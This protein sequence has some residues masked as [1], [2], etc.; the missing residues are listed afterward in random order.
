MKACVVRLRATIMLLDRD[1][2]PDGLLLNGHVDIESLEASLGVRSPHTVSKR[3]SS[4]SHL[5]TWFLDETPKTSKS[6]LSEQS[7]WEYL[8]HL[9]RTGAAASKG[10]GAVRAVKFFHHVLGFDF[11]RALGSRRIGG[12]S[13]QMLAGARWVRQAVELTVG[14]VRC[15]HQLSTSSEAH[16]WDKAIASYTLVAL[17]G[18]CRHSDLSDVHAIKRDLDPDGKG[19]LIL[20]LGQRKTSRLQARSRRLLPV[21]IPTIGITGTEWVSSALQALGAVGIQ[22]EG[23]ISGPLLRP[24]TSAEATRLCRRETRSQDI[25]AFLRKVMSSLASESRVLQIS[26]H[27]LKRTAL[28]WG[29]KYGLTPGEKSILGRHASATLGSQAVYSVD[30]ASAPARSLQRVILDIASG[31]F[32]PDNP[33]ASYFKPKPPVSANSGQTSTEPALCPDIPPVKPCGHHGPNPVMPAG[34]CSR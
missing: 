4:F 31:D 14:E 11:T 9:K 27:S 16:P 22:V 26:S 33:I 24:P 19:F 32:R 6:I 7:V 10:S 34:I 12:I 1:C 5:V 15:L 20:F 8:L 17:Y 3:V 28:S 21:L 23:D 13:E 25:T 30:L 29:S 2:V 18:R